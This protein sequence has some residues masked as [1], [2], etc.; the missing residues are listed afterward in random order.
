[1]LLDP[2]NKINFTMKVYSTN[3]FNNLL[4]FYNLNSLNLQIKLI[5]A[6]KVLIFL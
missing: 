1:M 5:K 3:K 6:L 4:Q 2:K